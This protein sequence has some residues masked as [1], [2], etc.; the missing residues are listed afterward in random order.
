MYTREGI[1]EWTAAVYTLQG[2]WKTHKHP[3]NDSRAASSNT[4]SSVP[5]GTARAS[6]NIRLTVSCSHFPVSAMVAVTNTV[7]GAID[8]SGTV[9]FSASNARGPS[10]MLTDCDTTTAAT[11]G[12][13][14]ISAPG[15][16]VTSALKLSMSARSVRSTWD[17]DRVQQRHGL[18]ARGT[19]TKGLSSDSVNF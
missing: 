13:A 18:V 1:C 14:C 5:R 7:V 10:I 8:T 12:S 17:V 15:G 6:A 4:C 19:C 9:G 16:S 11:G 2:Y 3:V